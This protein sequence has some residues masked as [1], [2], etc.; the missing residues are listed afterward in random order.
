MGVLR[1]AVLDVEQGRPDGVGD[2]PTALPGRRRRLAALPAQLAHRGDHG[3]APDA[4]IADSAASD[5][6]LPLLDRDA[7]L[8]GLQTS[9]SANA[10]PAAGDALED[11]AG[12]SGVT[13]R[14]SRVTKN[15]FISNT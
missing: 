11:G 7:P 9:S 8:L 10:N 4:K 1:A 12:G 3:R 2:L 14:L 15:R 5:A 13:R 6:V